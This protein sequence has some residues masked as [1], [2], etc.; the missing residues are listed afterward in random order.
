MVVKVQP[1]LLAAGETQ[2]DGAMRNPRCRGTGAAMPRLPTAAKA[3]LA[4]VGKRG[5]V[6]SGF[7]AGFVSRTFGGSALVD[8]RHVG[9]EECFPPNAPVSFGCGALVDKGEACSPLELRR[10]RVRSAHLRLNRRHRHGPGIPNGFRLD[11]LCYRGYPAGPR[12]LGTGENLEYPSAQ[13]LRLK[14]RRNGPGSRPTLGCE[15]P[16]PR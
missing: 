1:T 3:S 10:M 6:Q 11:F 15:V 2:H 4:A 14:R 13:G 16:V 8:L 12:N 7:R 5:A 9:T